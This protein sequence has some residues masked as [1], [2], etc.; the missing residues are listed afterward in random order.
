VHGRRLL[1]AHG[2]RDHTTKPKASAAFARAAQGVAESATYVAVH[3]EGHAL[4]RR[5][6]LWHDLATG[7][8]LA[9]V[10]G[11]D[12]VDAVRADA[13]AVVTKALAGSSELDV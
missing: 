5:A 7:F 2:L 1:L 3:G 12:P 9:T 10:C 6:R 13:A 11:V 4:L 8:V